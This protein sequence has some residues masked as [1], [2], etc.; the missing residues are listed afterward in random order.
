MGFSGVAPDGPASTW[1]KEAL[2][3]TTSLMSSFFSPE[4]S[5]EAGVGAL[6]DYKIAS[7]TLAILLILRV[8]VVVVSFGSPVTSGGLSTFVGFSIFFV[9]GFYQICTSFGWHGRS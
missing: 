6:M 3:L 7:K 8:D 1:I 9:F 4:A 2:A 5:A